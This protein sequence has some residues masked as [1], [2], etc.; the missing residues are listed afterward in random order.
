MATM[1]RKYGKN[2]AEGNDVCSDSLENIGD[3]STSFTGDSQGPG[4]SLPDFPARGIAPLA[5]PSVVPGAPS[6]GRGDLTPGKDPE[7][8]A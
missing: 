6:A 5:E 1:Q 2:K 4:E 3:S 7:H 8:F